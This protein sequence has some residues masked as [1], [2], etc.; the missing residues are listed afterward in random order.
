MLELPLDPA[1][2]L[3]DLKHLYQALVEC[4]APIDEINTVRKH[5]SAI[6]GGRLAAL[7]PKSMK[8]KLGVS[9]VPEGYETALAS[10]PTLPDPTTIADVLSV[11]ERYDLLSR[12]P[13]VV[14]AKL[15][16]PDT[17]QETPKADD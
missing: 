3:A 4:G 10:G 7:V 9:D 8:V 1:I 17:M 6:K 13:T 15:L 2:T 12:V 5:L 16:D 14:R 11:I